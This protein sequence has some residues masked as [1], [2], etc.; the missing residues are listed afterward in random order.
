MTNGIRCWCQ[1]CGRELEPS[2]TG[3]C[4]YCGKAGKRCEAT[5]SVAIGLKLSASTTRTRVY[6][7]WRNRRIRAT[8]GAIGIDAAIALVSTLAGLFAGNAFGALI[9]FVVSL[10]IIIISNVFFKRRVKTIVREIRMLC[11]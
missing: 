3:K 6:F 4:P 11:L 10:V 8:I 5:A 1:H 2:H 7:E 9:G